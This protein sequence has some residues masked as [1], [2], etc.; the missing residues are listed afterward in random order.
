VGQRVLEGNVFYVEILLEEDVEH[1]VRKYVQAAVL[2][3]GVGRLK[4][5]DEVQLFF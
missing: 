2:A 4:C 1:A 3:D 5:V